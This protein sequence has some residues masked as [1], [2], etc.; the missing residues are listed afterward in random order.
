MKEFLNYE[1]W[2]GVTI[3]DFFTVIG[4]IA[5][6][7]YVFDSLIKY[8]PFFQ[9]LKSKTYGKLSDNI[10]LRSLK[11]K[12]V[13]SSIELMLNQTVNQLRNELPKGWINRAVIKWVGKSLPP[14]L[15]DKQLIIKIRPEDDQDY[16]YLNAIYYFYSHSIFPE[17]HKIVPSCIKDAA[18]LYLVQRTIDDNQPY[19][20]NN[21][22]KHF[23]DT[24]SLNEPLVAGYY[25]DFLRIDEYGFFNSAFIREVDS[26]ANSLRFSHERANIEAEIRNIS[27]HLLKFE[28]LN[29]LSQLNDDDW[30]KTLSAT[31]YGFILVAKPEGQRVSG[32]TPYV[33]R[34]KQKLRLGIKRLYILG[35]YAE[36]TFV[37]EVISSIM[38]IREYKLLET[39]KL[40]RD[41]RGEA[42]GIG[43]LFIIDEVR[44]KLM[45]NRL[46]IEEDEANEEIN[47]FSV[48]KPNENKIPIVETANSVILSEP[49]LITEIIAVMQTLPQNEG[50]VFLGAI[51]S[52]LKNKVPLFNQYHYG[53][54][55]LRQLITKLKVFDIKEIGEGT[56]KAVYIKFKTQQTEN[57]LYN[58]KVKVEEELDEK[59]KFLLYLTSIVSELADKEGWAYLGKVGEKIKKDYQNF[60][61]SKYGSLNLRHFCQ[62]TQLFDVRKEGL[63]MFKSIYLKVRENGNTSTNESSNRIPTKEIIESALIEIVT[64][65]TKYEEWTFLANIGWE[66][67]KLYPNFDPMQ[68]KLQSLRQFIE[69]TGKFELKSKEGHK[70]V[71]LVKLKNKNQ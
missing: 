19:L 1:L 24:I 70:L 15:K 49:Q 30:H 59:G 44:E 43:A 69:S 33:K 9:K 8:F 34:A 47:E 63:G 23:V 2:K 22:R 35:C 13:S 17:T 71:I 55:T 64:R 36:Q 14:D 67:K 61:P 68:Y 51:G 4:I 56:A 11:K 20:S 60:S 37:K 21:F 25:G 27:E 54:S 41:Y 5:I 66:I 38:D 53:C 52:Q 48:P 65:A 50:W 3:G 45:K 6:I 46:D 58:K 10:K 42:N 12:A 29:K 26:L 57:K 16:N 7:L 40:Y 32:V 31:S 18:S 39:F 28:K 62:D